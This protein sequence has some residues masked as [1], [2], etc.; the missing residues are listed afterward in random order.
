LSFCNKHKFS[1]PYIFATF[2][3]SNLDYFDLPELIAWNI[4]G[5]GNAK[6]KELENLS[7][8]QKLNF[9]GRKLVLIIYN[10]FPWIE[11]I[12]EYL[13]SDLNLQPEPFLWYLIFNLNLFQDIW[14]PS[15]KYILRYLISILQTY[16]N[17]SN[18]P[19]LNLS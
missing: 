14:Y 12:L 8:W 2:D 1:N 19:P 9:F 17:M 6:L 18:I 5:L 10:Y 15:C 13:I 11:P 4:K 3:I 7:L 16:F